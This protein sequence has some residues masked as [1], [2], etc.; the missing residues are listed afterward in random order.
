VT[1]S[2]HWA[3]IAVLAGITWAGYASATII[4]SEKVALDARERAKLESR[5]CGHGQKADLIDAQRFQT[6][7]LTLSARITCVPYGHIAGY[8]AL[9]TGVCEKSGARW[10]C[11]DPA[12]A[13]RMQVRS[14]EL[15][16][17]YVDSVTPAAAVELV[18]FV[19]SASTFNGQNTSALL[20]GRCRI[21]DGHTAPFPGALNFNYN[22]DGP[23][24]SITKDCWD[25][26]C[27]VFF[28]DFGIWVP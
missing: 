7:P 8:P 5:V 2:Q 23:S 3:S 6:T 28:T 9:K 4:P 21:S 16:V 17:E 1:T 25:S 18:K 15:L 10:T 27:R 12:L 13:L 19:S 26:Q 11:E 24:A 22:C 20:V 14:K